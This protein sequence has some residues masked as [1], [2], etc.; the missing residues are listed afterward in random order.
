MLVGTWLP[1]A[2]RQA[3]AASVQRRKIHYWPQR[4]RRSET[5]LA[6]RAVGE[7]A[8]KFSFARSVV[9]DA[10]ALAPLSNY[11]DEVDTVLIDNLAD[12]NL[13]IRLIGEPQGTVLFTGG[14]IVPSSLLS[15]PHL[16]FLHIHPG[17]LPDIR[18][19]DCT[20]WSTLIAGR[21]SASCF[22]MSPG[23][24]TGDIIMR[25]W[26]PPIMLDGL[27]RVYDAQTIYRAVYSFID[28]WVRAAVL[29]TLLQTRTPDFSN[30]DSIRQAKSEGDTYHFMH[31]R[32]KEYI[33]SRL[34]NREQACNLTP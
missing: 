16:R 18:G 1:R 26:L 2:I 29:R 12:S 32:T 5:A 21:P 20:L 30:L 14:G 24:D 8:A 7:A 27:S 9:E 13:R 10:H 15:L 25:R 4:L 11:S 23:I 31:R 28:P 33:A 17:F 34:L 19:A 6:E 3:Y 22:Y